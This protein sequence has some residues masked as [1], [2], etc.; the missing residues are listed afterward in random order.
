MQ[1]DNDAVFPAAPTPDDVA[2]AA[3]LGFPAAAPGD[4][5]IDNPDQNY[6]ELAAGGTYPI[7]PAEV[8]FNLT[9][10]P[11]Y[12]FETGNVLIPD[13]SL[14]VPLGGSVPFAGSDVSFAF[15]GNISYLAFLDDLNPP[16]TFG[17]D[18]GTFGVGVTATW[19]GI[20]FD[21]RYIDNF[22]DTAD[23]GSTGVFTISKSF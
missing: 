10:S 23:F 6:I 16:G 14:S 5:L 4:V 19:F 21:A 12:Y 11:D 22:D 20:D 7:G 1:D 17:E 13:F 3:A 15:S 2:I 8:G 9:Y 18:Y